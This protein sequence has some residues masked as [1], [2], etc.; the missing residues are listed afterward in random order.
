MIG[1]AGITCVKDYKFVCECCK[2]ME[3]KRGS[4]TVELSRP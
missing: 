1:L 4:T 2:K 3:D